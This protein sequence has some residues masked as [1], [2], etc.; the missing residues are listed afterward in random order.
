MT[1]ARFARLF[2]QQQSKVHVTVADGIPTGQLAVHLGADFIA[3]AANG[4]P[5]V[6]VE[7]SRAPSGGNDAI[8][9]RGDD[10]ASRAAPTHVRDRDR[11]VGVG[12]EYRHA[13]RDGDGSRARRAH[14]LRI[15]S[16]QP[17]DGL[18][19]R[20]VLGD[21]RPVHLDRA[22]QS[23]YRRVKRLMKGQPPLSAQWSDLS[24]RKGE[25]TG[26]PRRGERQDTERTE[27][28]DDFASGHIECAVPIHSR[29]FSRRRMRAPSA[30][31]RS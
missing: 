17:H 7:V 31:R 20:R 19:R 24:G 22:H 25:I 4:G 14:E 12:H 15:E 9:E 1:D 13:V 2:A 3:A 6:D 26:L 18:P 27:L 29:P 23:G 8:N 11:A 21:C 16:L 10:P 5:E 30:L 28:L